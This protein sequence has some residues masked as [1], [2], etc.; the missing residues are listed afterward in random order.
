MENETLVGAGATRVLR[1]IADAPGASTL[2]DLAQVTGLHVNTLRT[3]LATL[4]AARR[5]SRS[6]VRAGGRGRPRWGYAVRPGEHAA[7]ARALVAGLVGLEE[8][9]AEQAALR[10]GRVWGRQVVDDLGVGELVPRE[11][12]RAVLAHT[13]FAPED[14]PDGPGADPPL[15]LTR[16]PIID[17]AREHPEVVCRVHQGM[18]EGALEEAPD[19]RET[20]DAPG[21]ALRPFAE[22]G[23]C[24]VLLGQ[25][26][27][28]AP[29]RA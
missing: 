19:A 6:P 2:E 16:C 14:G 12:A 24:W 1:A 9:Q 17:A 20:P 26:G 11:R 29:G 10:G 4:L 27:F 7:L 8:G 23:A 13:G 25:P 28:G 15:R 5:I 3:H 21:V 18:L 22:P